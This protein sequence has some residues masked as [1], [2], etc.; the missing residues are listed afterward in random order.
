MGLALPLGHHTDPARADTKP[1]SVE[2]LSQTFGAQCESFE[3]RLRYLL[4]F[5]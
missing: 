1:L 5:L 4:D 2:A 3:K